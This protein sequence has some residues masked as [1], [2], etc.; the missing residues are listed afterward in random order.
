VL[1][2]TYDLYR[3][4]LSAIPGPDLFT[5]IE[6]L[7]RIREPIQDRPQEDY[8]LD[9]K[10]EWKEDALR[11]VASI[12]N[13]FGGILLIGVS[14]EGGKPKDIRGIQSEREIKTRIAS[15]IASNISPT[16]PY[17]IGECTLPNDATKRLCVIRIRKGSQLYLLT[18]KG[19]NSPVYVRNA[20]ESRPAQAAELRALIEQRSGS[21]EAG[22]VSPSRL[23]EWHD[24]TIE[25]KPS[26]QFGTKRMASGTYFK[27]V[28]LPL[29]QSPLI[30]DQALETEFKRIVCVHYPGVIDFVRSAP[31]I[32]FDEDRDRDWYELRWLHRGLDFERCWRVN[33]L[34]ELGFA[35]QAKY[36]LAGYGLYWSL[37][38][39]ALGLIS[40]LR[41]TKSWWE[42]S[43]HF[44]EARLIAWL[45]V[46]GLKIYR[47][48]KYPRGFAPLF[49]NRG[50]WPEKNEWPLKPINL[51]EYPFSETDMT[52]AQDVLSL[53]N[54]DSGGNAVAQID[55][56]YS[57]LNEELPEVVA[58]VLNQFIRSLKHAANLKRLREETNYLV[59]RL[60]L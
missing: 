48:E 10:Q 47:L 28:V 40:T 16:P 43:N 20:D 37:C 38:D 57:S 22:A 59:S 1:T 17:D 27:A 46:C 2:V 25:E 44:G 7:C 55:L 50:N 24:F 30:L 21:A 19:E 52:L 23:A 34:G 36:S 9:F 53:S 32:E 3:D 42:A 13:T 49:Y 18:K 54:A 8:R 56:N 45:G 26:S 51:P 11:V 14:E 31:V 33:S 41:A 58:L 6:A 29:G 5:A 15:S 12:A 35:T 39:I 60:R 4:D